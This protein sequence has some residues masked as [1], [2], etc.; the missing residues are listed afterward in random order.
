MLDG[1]DSL[2][3]TRS[4]KHAG[5]GWLR[6]RRAVLLLVLP[7]SLA[8]ALPT[9]A[10]ASTP[11]VVS[12]GSATSI[13]GTGATLNGTVNA[14]GQSGTTYQFDYDYSRDQ[15][16]TSG[17]ASG[18]PAFQTTSTPLP[19]G[20]GDQPVS[21]ATVTGFTPGD[22]IC[23]ELVAN[24][25]TSNQAVGSP[26]VT[27]TMTPMVITTGPATSVVN[28]GATLNGSINDEGQPN[29]SYYFDLGTPSSGACSGTQA[30][31]LT[32]LGYAD[33]SAHAV[34]GT[35]TG[36]TPSTTYC[37]YVV[38]SSSSYVFTDSSNFATFTTPPP[39]TLTVNVTGTDFGGVS[40]PDYP[41]YIGGAEYFHCG[42][43]DITG[44]QASY[45]EGTTVV[46][47]TAAGANGGGNVGRFDGWSGACSGTSP[48]C[49][50]PMN[51][52]HTVGA[53][54]TCVTGCGSSGPSR[55]AVGTAVSSA[56]KV[57]AKIAAI[58]KAGGYQA[59]VSALTPGTLT[60][61]WSSG[62]GT[63]ATRSIVVA[64]GSKTF[65]KAGRAKLKIKLTRAGR[66]LLKR[67]KHLKLT[68]VGSFKPRHGNKVTKQRT[69]RLTG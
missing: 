58:L 16:C 67:S 51:T 63:H 33:S 31:A 28:G 54:F 4:T 68:A 6:A 24:P 55:S 20:S 38:T 69:I 43:G 17:G 62:S 27:F 46:T 40:S 59:S 45:V 10:L 41:N 50:V 49:T 66:A 7:V 22:S 44:C 9:V 3:R 15:F 18:T 65:G 29:T 57:T 12:T 36:L 14:E 23:F 21:A 34:S 11:P 39:A 32:P 35:L 13:T 47:L 26:P 60:I 61:S 52:D 1:G 19:G 48:T 30:T 5:A 37:D 56:L 64:S 2:L 42:F 53:T 8:L 25:G